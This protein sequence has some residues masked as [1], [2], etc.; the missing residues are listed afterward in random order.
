MIRNIVGGQF[1]FELPTCYFL[2]DSS[3]LGGYVTCTSL[4]ECRQI[5]DMNYGSTANFDSQITSFGGIIMY[6]SEEAFGQR[7]RKLRQS[8]GISTNEMAVN[9]RVSTNYL[10]KIERG[11]RSPS[12][13]F[14]IRLSLILG[15]STDFLL[16]GKTEETININQ[17]ALSLAEQLVIFANRNSG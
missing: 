13:D 4:P 8:K 17:L 7:I 3:L 14:V 2:T 16:M 15:I 1:A 11:L 5:T 12:F 10:G 6:F 9:L